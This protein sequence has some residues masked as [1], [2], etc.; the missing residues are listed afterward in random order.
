MAK[1][2]LSKEERRNNCPLFLSKNWIKR[3]D[4][5]QE[6]HLRNNPKKNA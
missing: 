6:K 2:M 5:K 4:E 1:K 3:T